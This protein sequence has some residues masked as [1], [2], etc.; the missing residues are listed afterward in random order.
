MQGG[1]EE[2]KV[3]GRTPRWVGGRKVRRLVVGT[4]ARGERGGW[5]VGT[6]KGLKGSGSGSGFGIYGSEFRV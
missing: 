3:G 1:G 6:R 2:A 5:F 4:A